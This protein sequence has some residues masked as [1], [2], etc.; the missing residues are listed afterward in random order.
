MPAAALALV[1]LVW[2]RSGNRAV[3]SLFAAGTPLATVFAGAGVAAGLEGG[4]IAIGMAAASLV[5]A[6]VAHVAL[7]RDQIVRRVWC[8]ATA[9][10][11]T[12]TTVIAL[13]G[14]VPSEAV[15]LVLLLL[16][17]APL[18]LAALFGDPIGGPSVVANGSWG[19]LVLGVGSMWAWFGDRGASD[20]EAY[21]LPLAIGLWVAAGLVLW[22]RPATDTTAAG[23]T[24]L[25]AAGAAVAVLPSLATAGDSELR[26]LVLVAIGA[27]LVIAGS[28]VPELVR[29]I[30]VRMLVVA[31]GWVAA[32]GAA[33]LRGSTIATGG[34]SGL[35]IEFWPVLALAVGVV[36]T[37]L[38][39]RDRAVPERAAE[40]TL[41]VSVTLAA[42][43]TALAIAD[44]R[45]AGLRAAVLLGCLA[46]VH[47]VGTATRTRPFSGP[48]LTWTSL[49]A[50]V[51]AG[52][53]AL[54]SGA[55][56]PFD[57]VTVPIG[58][59][60]VA[61]GAVHLHR[62][63]GARSWPT[64]GPGLAVLLLPALLAD[65]TDPVLWRLVALGVAAVAAVVT[66]A[67]LRLQ[68][69][70][71][72]GGAVL[73]VHAIAQLWPWITLL[74]EAVWWWLWLGIAGALLIAIAATYERQ[75]RLAR[76]LGRTIASLR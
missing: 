73:F 65:W 36:A 52:G 29:G 23:R 44:G 10:L 76:G 63:P 27:V 2:A 3:S 6:V 4:S 8:S 61:A 13:A 45:N 37:V 47:V 50:A 64:L 15:W 60:L 7:P 74:Y 24:T 5:A 49:A 70:L 40:I 59:A 69:P 66:G 75:V 22:R 67:V 41:A 33:L 17:P 1:G 55:V 54:V 57:L 19:S 62:S 18:I 68:A 35:P 51:V 72:L 42:V 20:V 38:W 34:T 46:V 12:V 21:T 14:P 26:T 39:A 43:P 58:A 53:F 31:T 71:L 48:A 28:F 16:A 9:I 30:P 25:L 11:V 32:T 56:D